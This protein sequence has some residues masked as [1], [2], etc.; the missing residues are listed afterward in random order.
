VPSAHERTFAGF[1]F[2]VLCDEL[3]DATHAPGGRHRG[4]SASRGPPYW[5]ES[6]AAPEVAGRPRILHTSS[7]ALLRSG[8]VMC[9]GSNGFGQRGG[10]VT[11]GGSAPVLVAGLSDATA[12]AAGALHTCAVRRSGQVVCWG[13]NADGELGNGTTSQ[14]NYP[15]PVLGLTDAQS[16]A[17]GTT[18]TC[19]VRVSGQVACWG[20]NDSGQIG[21]FG[22]R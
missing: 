12:I 5:K 17:A 9:W 7:C 4:R 8:Q 21:A 1:R 19:A 2:S 20:Y 16:L 6:G 10:E 15:T 18:H 11:S 13:Y 3:A 22:W 14:A